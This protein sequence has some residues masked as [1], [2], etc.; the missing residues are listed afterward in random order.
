MPEYLHQ[1]HFTLQEARESL[2][3]LRD[4]ITELVGLKK[5]LDAINYNIYKHEYFGGL[6]PNGSKF[7]PNELQTLV[8]LMKEMDERGIL[9]KSIEDGLIDFPS[10]RENGEEVYLCWK[11]GEE[12]ILFWHFPSDGF[13]G[14]QSIRQL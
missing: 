12:D 6:G 5:R 11:V 4:R 3:S 8:S 7:H 13:Q 2:A 10:V 9:I 1:K 14:R